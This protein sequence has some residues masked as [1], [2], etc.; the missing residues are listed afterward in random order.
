MKDTAHQFGKLELSAAQLIS[1]ADANGRSIDCR[2]YMEALAFYGVSVLFH[3][4]MKPSAV[5]TLG[6]HRGRHMVSCGGGKILRRFRNDFTL[7]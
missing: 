1:V 4:D 6:A 7:S 3:C 5:E 2:G